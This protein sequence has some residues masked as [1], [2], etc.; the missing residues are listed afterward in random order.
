[1]KNDQVGG[2]KEE[3]PFLSA[4]IPGCKPGEWGEG[5]ALRETFLMYFAEEPAEFLRWLANKYASWMFDNDRYIDPSFRDSRAK[6]FLRAAMRDL[7]YIAQCLAYTAQEAV[8]KDES[9]SDVEIGWFADS[10][11]VEVQGLADKIDARINPKR[12]AKK[13]V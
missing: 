6:A 7:H 9:R 2:T 12:K 5:L 4:S 8:E 1:M 13:N 11:A 10:L 3:R